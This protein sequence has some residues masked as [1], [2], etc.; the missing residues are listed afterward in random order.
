MVLVD[1]PGTDVPSRFVMSSPATS[2]Q[3]SMFAAF[4]VWGAVAELF[5]APGAPGP[6]VDEWFPDAHPASAPPRTATATTERIV[7]GRIS[8][9]RLVMVGS[10]RPAPATSNGPHR[11][12]IAGTGTKKSGFSVC[13]QQ[14]GPSGQLGLPSLPA[15]TRDRGRHFLGL[16]PRW[17]GNAGG[18]AHGAHA[19]ELADM[20][21]VG[22]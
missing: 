4:P 2:E 20:G 3:A 11:Q 17:L 19:C 9:M 12:R 13:I 21:D 14:F 15:W 10:F 7:Q 18:E 16:G 1:W 6:A 22:G 5:D 8:Y